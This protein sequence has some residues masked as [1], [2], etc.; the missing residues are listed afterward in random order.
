MIIRSAAPTD[1][2][3]IV[4]FVIEEAREAEARL[5]DREVVGAAVEAGLADRALVR[6]WVAEHDGVP[7]AAIATVREWS[8][9]HNAA[10]WW[11]QLAF[12]APEQRGRGVLRALVDHVRA[13]ALNQ[14]VLELRLYVM[15]ANARAVRA[16]EKLGFA[17]S[18][19]V[20]MALR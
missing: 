14:G 18:P 13:V 12:V 6:Y 1:L 15:P 10:Y 3:A 16:Y 7:C 8:D 4:E 2:Q 5:L 11:I 17:V 9:W 19:Y 20:M